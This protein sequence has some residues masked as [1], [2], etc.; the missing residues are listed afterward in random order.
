MAKVFAGERTW[1]HPVLRPLE[2]GIYKICGI[3]ETGEQPWTRYAGAMLVFSAVGIVF[4]YVFLRAATVVPAQSA[5]LRQP[6]PGP[7]VQHRRQFR[8]QHQLAGLLGRNHHELSQPDGRRWP[9]TTSGP[10]RPA[11]PWRS[12][13]C[14][15]SRATRSRRSATS[16]WISRAAR[17]TSCCRSRWSA[18]CCCARRA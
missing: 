15:V 2:A 16:G 12:R 3:D 18:R 13:S 14:A 1:L 8:H 17:C 6:G 4:T 11:S 9:L 7:V 10:P 5:G